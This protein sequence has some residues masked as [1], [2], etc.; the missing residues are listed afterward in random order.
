V[1][2]RHDDL[3]AR[4]VRAHELDDLAPQRRLGVS[5]DRWYA[6]G[7]VEHH[8]RPAHAPNPPVRS[9]EDHHEE[10]ALVVKRVLP[11]REFRNRL[12]ADSLQ[13]L[14]VLLA[15]LERLLH[16]DHPVPKHACLWHM[17]VSRQS[18]V[19]SQQEGLPSLPTVDCRLSTLLH[20]IATPASLKISRAMIRRW[21]SLVP[22]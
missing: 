11:K 10:V 22:S 1:P 9:L 6:L 2:E 12:A 4:R 13:E 16:R 7:V 21:I 20:P 5:G 15:P 14:E 19:N 18:T 17:R 3:R 8:P